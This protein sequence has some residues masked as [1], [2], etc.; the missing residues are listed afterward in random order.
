[1]RQSIEGNE[2]KRRA[3]VM[4]AMIGLVAAAIILTADSGH[5]VMRVL[6]MGMAVN[7]VFIVVGLATRRLPMRWA[8]VLVPLPLAFASLFPFLAWHLGF[9]VI[10]TVRDTLTVVLWACLLFP[11][12][13]VAFGTRRGL[14]VSVGT[15]VALATLAAPVLMFG[16]AGARSPIVVDVALQLVL[17]Y[18]GLIVLLWLLSSRLE[19]LTNAQART[20]TLAD[21]VMTDVLTGVPNRRRLSD[22]LDLLMANARRYQ[23]QVSVVFVDI[24]RFKNVNDTYGHDV[25]DQVLIELARRL[26]DSVRDADVV[27]RWGG[28]EFLIVAPETGLDDAEQLAQRCWGRVRDSPFAGVGTVTASFGVVTLSEDDD[29]RSFL[30]RADLALYTAKSEGRD[31]VVAIDAVDDSTELPTLNEPVS[32]TADL[33][34]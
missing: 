31:R 4:L 19:S 28:E 11:L 17:I 32:D 27:G 21:Q 34:E 29:R 16:P 33:G 2:G 20:A 9:E 24:D 3:Y 14:V 22:E 23:R 26:E 10:E 13:F 12:A 1:V 7:G 15:L 30:R 5:R 25:G 8:D 18:A 6:V